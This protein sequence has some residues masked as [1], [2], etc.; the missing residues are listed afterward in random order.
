MTR[1]AIIA[2]AIALAGSSLIGAAAS[3]QPY[4]YYHHHDANYYHRD[5]YSP[6]EWHDSDWRRSSYAGFSDWDRARRVDYYRHNLYRPADGYEWRYVDGNFVLG[7][8]ATGRIIDV[9]PGDG[10]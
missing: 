7:A 3:A 6:R 9:V 4:E 8:V 1:L 10:W 2:A 5:A